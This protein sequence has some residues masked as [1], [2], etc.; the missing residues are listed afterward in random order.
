[1]PYASHVWPYGL[2][3]ISVFLSSDNSPDFM[4]F[5]FQFVFDDVLIYFLEDV[6]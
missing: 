5:I 1:M 6:G 3:F 4:P 2:G